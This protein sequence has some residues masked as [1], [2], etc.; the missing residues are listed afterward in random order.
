M[1]IIFSVETD[2]VVICSKKYVFCLQN[3]KYQNTNGF[4]GSVI[5]CLLN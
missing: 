5:T 3:V 1:K 4:L 2:I